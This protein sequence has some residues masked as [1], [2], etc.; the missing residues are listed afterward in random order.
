MKNVSLEYPAGRL[1]RLVVRR[2]W[3]PDVAEKELNFAWF[4]PL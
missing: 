1:S 4:V 2:A 3:D